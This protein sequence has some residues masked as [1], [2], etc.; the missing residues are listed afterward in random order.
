MAEI[1]IDIDEAVLDR[2][3]RLLDT[4]TPTGTV[5]AALRAVASQDRAAALAE[6][7]ELVAEGGVDLDVLRDKR[8]YRN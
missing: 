5:D 2:A 4:T 1:L 3:T 6:M 7:R 8:R